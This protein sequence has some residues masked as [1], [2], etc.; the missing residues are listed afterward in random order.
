MEQDANLVL[1][2]FQEEDSRGNFPDFSGDEERWQQEKLQ[3]ATGDEGRRQQDKS[4][5]LMA[6]QEQDREGN[7]LDVNGKVKRW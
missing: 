5:M 4:L 6:F 2:A 7:F 3:Q 1:K